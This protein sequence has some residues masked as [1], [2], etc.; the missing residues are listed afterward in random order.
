MRRSTEN[1]RKQRVTRFRHKSGRITIR[2][3]LQ[4]NEERILK[5]FGFERI[6][7]GYLMKKGPGVPRPIQQKKRFWRILT[8]NRQ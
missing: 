5:D 1:K 4:A 6:E 7:D 3:H 8:L 2:T